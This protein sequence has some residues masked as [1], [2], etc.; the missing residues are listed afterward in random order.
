MPMGQQMMG[1]M[2]YGAYGQQYGMGVMGPGMQQGMMQPGMMQQGMMQ[3]GML[4]GML[5]GM[6]QPNMLLPMVDPLQAQ[7]S[8]VS[9]DTL[10]PSHVP[11]HVPEA[12]QEE[13]TILRRS[14]AVLPLLSAFG[15]ALISLGT[16]PVY[17]V[18]CLSE[19]VRAFD[20]SAVTFAQLAESIQKIGKKSPS[21]AH[22]ANRD[23]RDAMRILSLFAPTTVIEQMAYDPRFAQQYGQYGYQQPY[24]YRY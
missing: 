13:Q 7:V 17:L 24:G 20:M 1:Q 11:S 9:Q 18:A 2:G 22:R 12:K 4:P 16:L 5:P 10:V 21:H 3:Q 14:S 15:H 6:L 19:K 23:A 8:T